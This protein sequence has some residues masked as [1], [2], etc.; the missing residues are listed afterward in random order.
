M[1]E[2]GLLFRA[3]KDLD[4][5]LSIETLDSAF[6]RTFFAF[7]RVGGYQVQEKADGARQFYRFK[8]PAQAGYPHM[9]ELFSRRPDILGPAQDG[10]L[11]PIP[12]GD[13]ASSLSAILLDDD[14]YHFLRAGRRLVQ[15]V[16]LIGPECL[17]ALKAKAWLD[18]TRRKAAGE[19]VDSKDIRKHRGDVLRLWQIIDPAA[20]QAAPT[21]VQD[22]LRAFLAVLEADVPDP[23]QLGIS[24]PL[25]MILTDLRRIYSIGP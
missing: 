3:T 9:L 11:T 7:V 15:G 24:Q 6:S 4:I 12:V 21:V 1:E 22:D 25:G 5:V 8:K 18:L 14:Y 20:V 19:A 23:K 2:A 17:I 16:P 13:E 10:Q